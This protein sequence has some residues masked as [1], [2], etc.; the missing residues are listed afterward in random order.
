M[1]REQGE[2]VADVAM[3]AVAQAEEIA[4]EIDLIVVILIVETDGGRR[5][6][7]QAG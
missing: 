1:D 4:D 3:N 7:A 2:R 6:I 5:M